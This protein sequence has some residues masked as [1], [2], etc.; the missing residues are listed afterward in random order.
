MNHTAYHLLCLEA[1]PYFSLSQR[2]SP[3]LKEWSSTVCM[4]HSVSTH[5]WMC[6]LFL[7]GVTVNSTVVNIA[8]QGPVWVPVLNSF[9]SLVSIYNWNCWVIWQFYVLIFG[10]M[11]SCF[12]VTI[13]FYIPASTKQGFPVLHIFAN[14]CSVQ[15]SSVTQSCPT[16]GDPM[17]CSTPGL[18][19]HHQLLEFTQTHVHW[20]GEIGRASCRE[21]V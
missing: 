14:T 21:R 1:Y 7:P 20:G 3:L 9:G 12:P 15:L 2:F 19:V 6:G 16:L 18:P 10:E 13:P 4:S 5:Q 11:P 17:N 8:T